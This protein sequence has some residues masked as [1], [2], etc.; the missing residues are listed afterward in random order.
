VEAM[1]PCGHKECGAINPVGDSERGFV[2]FKGL[3][4]GEVEA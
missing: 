2:V 3:E 4:K 1:E